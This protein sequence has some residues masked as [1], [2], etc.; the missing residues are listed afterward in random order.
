M[1]TDNTAYREWVNAD[2][3]TAGAYLGSEF[4]KAFASNPDWELVKGSAT[5]APAEE[6]PE[7]SDDSTEGE[8]TKVDPSEH[9]REE[10]NQLATEAGIE[11]PAELANKGAVADAINAKRAEATTAPAE[12]G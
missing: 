7:T 4:D 10:L 5:T 1:T 12:E 11:D 3:E 9:S 2:G 8:V 6:V